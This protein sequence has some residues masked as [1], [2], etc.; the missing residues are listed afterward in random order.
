MSLETR[1]NEDL[2]QAMLAKDAVR[3]RG[4]RAIKSAILLAKTAENAP[5]E[6]TGEHE[7][8][9]LQKLVKQRRDSAAIYTES[10]RPDL[11]QKENEEIGVIE[12][13]LPKQLSAD[14]IQQIVQRIIG[15]TGASGMKDM[16]RVMGAAT[17]ELAGKADSKTVA[18]IV[19][20]ILTAG[21]G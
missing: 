3:T 2:K 4:L 7:I 9:L 13:Y 18:E 6:L 19:K 14:E 8:A 21:Q 15:E 16:G 17:K 20:R 12:T 1:I 11:A 10:G 5:Q